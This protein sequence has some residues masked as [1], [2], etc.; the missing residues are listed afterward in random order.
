MYQLCKKGVPFIW[1][2]RCL[3]SFDNLKQCL[4]SPSVL[5]YP[6]FSANNEFIAQTDASGYSIGGILS[7][8]NKNPIAYAS[9]ALNNAEKRYPTI[10]KELLVIVWAV[11]YFR[12]YL[13][14]RKFKILTDHR[15]LVYLFNMRDP[16]SRL[17]KFRLTL[18]EYAYTVEYIKGT[19]NA[20]ADALSRI[21][22]TSNELKDISESCINVMTRAQTMK[23]QNLSVDMVPTDVRPDQPDVLGSHIKSKESVELK[24]IYKNSLESLRRKNKITRGKHPFCYV[25][26]LSTIF[27]NPDFQSQMT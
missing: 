12:P 7:N 25:N 18:E 13:Y 17:M 16:F 14:S 5:Q 11:K 22:F 23:L 3:Q 6:D 10:E 24:F 27:L 4:I 9:R 15:P 20:A 26:D 2:T 19:D 21:C 1:D 8:S